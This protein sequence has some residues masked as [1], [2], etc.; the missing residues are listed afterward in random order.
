[1]GGRED[2]IYLKTSKLYSFNF[3]PN[4]FNK[5]DPRFYYKGLKIY[6]F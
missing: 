1:M 4:Y 6:V 3:K 2:Q 5:N